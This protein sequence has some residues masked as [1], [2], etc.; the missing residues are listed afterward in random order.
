MQKLLIAGMIRLLGGFFILTVLL[1]SCVYE[2]KSPEPC[3]YEDVSL[4]TDVKPIFA[5]KGCT[6]C[7]SPNGA[8]GGV[9]L[10][11]IEG[12]RASLVDDV[13]IKSIEH[14]AGVS[15]M[16]KNRQKMPDCEIEVIRQWVKEGAKNN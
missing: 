10:E 14:N 4:S 16:P 9:E 8:S 2:H 15:A 13:L 7:H 1:S 11:T 12:L 6:G 3:S 5:D